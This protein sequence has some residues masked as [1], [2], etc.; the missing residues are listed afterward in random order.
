M[1]AE[2]DLP[3][4]IAVVGEEAAVVQLDLL[5]VL[6]PLHVGDGAALH[7]HGQAH[8]HALVEAHVLEAFSKGSRSVGLAILAL[9]A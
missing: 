1:W 2:G 7:R 8:H 4:P 9:E 5:A 3:Y 6:V